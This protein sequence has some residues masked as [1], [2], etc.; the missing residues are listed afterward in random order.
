MRDYTLFTIRV[1][2]SEACIS[3]VNIYLV[4]DLDLD[5]LHLLQ[6]R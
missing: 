6:V 5:L 4:T 3:L 1:L 2:S